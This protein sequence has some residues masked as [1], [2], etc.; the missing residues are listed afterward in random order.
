M[1]LQLVFSGGPVGWWSV[2]GLAW[3]GAVAVCVAAVANALAAGRGVVVAMEHEGVAPAVV[4]GVATTGAA[5]QGL[6]G[7]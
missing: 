2:V 1:C 7:C 6:C 5:V 3:M 4:A